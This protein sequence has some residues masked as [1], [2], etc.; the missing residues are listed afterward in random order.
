ML[1]YSDS[2]KEMGVLASRLAIARAVAAL[3]GVITRERLRPVFFHGSGGSVDRGGGSIDEQT[4]WWPGSSLTLYKATVQGEMVERTFASP[5]ILSVQLERIARRVAEG[6]ASPAPVPAPSRE[7]K[8]L[9]QR[10][11]RAY[12]ALLSNRLLPGSGR[13]G[14][15]LPISR[16]PEDRL[17]PDKTQA[18]VFRGGPARHSLGAVLDTGPHPSTHVVGNRRSLARELSLTRDSRLPASSRGTTCSGLLS[19]RWDSPSRRSS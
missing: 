19:R 2:A 7:L 17:P 4:S 13:A 1:G 9:A 10:A 5:E 18:G 16:P 11:S 8:R 15:R 6:V 12:R 14:H 3:D